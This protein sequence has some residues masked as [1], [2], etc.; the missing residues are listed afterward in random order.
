MDLTAQSIAVVVAVI[1]VPSGLRVLGIV[2]V[3]WDE[4]YRGKALCLVDIAL[5]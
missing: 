3:A 4:S 2:S 1:V 5:L